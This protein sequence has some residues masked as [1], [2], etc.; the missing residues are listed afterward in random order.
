MTTRAVLLG[1]LGALA[2]AGFKYINDDVLGLTPLAGN[3]FPIS[4]FGVLIL[5]VIVLNPLLSLVRRS[6][7]FQPGE[8]GVIVTFLADRMQ[9][10]GRDLHADDG[11]A[12]RA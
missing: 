5:L 10:S 2:I 11:A 1:F 4:V 8:L 3:H 6:W 9:H 7:R 12:D